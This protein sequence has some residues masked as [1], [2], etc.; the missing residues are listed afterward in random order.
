MKDIFYY[1]FHK[2]RNLALPFVSFSLVAGIS[3]PLLEY[4][5]N[6]HIKTSESGFGKMCSSW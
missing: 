6:N 3:I 1:Q 2:L 4:N 5:P